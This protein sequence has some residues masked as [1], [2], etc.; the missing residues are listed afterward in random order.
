MAD[1]SS[2]VLCC[3]GFVLFRVCLIDLCQGTSL[4]YLELYF[5]FLFVFGF[6]TSAM[7]G[8]LNDF[9]LNSLLFWSWLV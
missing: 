1:K 6:V 4:I 7:A 8:K 2:I 5:V 3:F 9:M